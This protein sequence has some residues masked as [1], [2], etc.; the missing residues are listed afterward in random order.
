MRLLWGV[1]LLLCAKVQACDWPELTMLVGVE[2]PPYI[3]VASQSGFELEL[4][5]QV[6][7]RLRRCAVFLHVPNG[8]LLEL[9]QQGQADLVSL[10]RTVPAGLYATDSYIRYE[11]VLVVHQQLASRIHQLNDLVGL[12]LIAFQNAQLFLPERYRQLIPQLAS[13]LEVVEQHQLPAMLLKNRVDALVMDKN[14]FNYFYRQTAPGDQQLKLL[15]LFG[16]NAYHLLGRNA[17]LVQSF[18]RALLE[19]KQSPEFTA[20]QLKY[21]QQINQ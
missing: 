6:S 14:I 3:E 2:K 9:Y 20:L 12:R 17:Q 21:F 4:L 13:Y 10:Q 7:L 1:L 16:V 5:Q 8:R 18:N 11:N 19:F 15:H